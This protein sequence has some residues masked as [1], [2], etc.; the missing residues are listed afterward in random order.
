MKIVTIFHQRIPLQP[1]SAMR[2]TVNLSAEKE[3]KWTREKKI[4]RRKEKMPLIVFGDGMFGKDGT[5]LK[6]HESGVTNVLWKML[7]QREARGEVALVT[8]DEYLTS[9]VRIPLEVYVSCG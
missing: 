9:Q 8:I 5:R 4:Q 2:S 7:K 1:V 6:G 3:Y